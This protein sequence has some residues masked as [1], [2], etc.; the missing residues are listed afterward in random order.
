MTAG[1]CRLCGQHSELRLSHV[2]PAFVFRWLRET[3]GTGH[4][5]RS[6]EPNVRVQ[7]GLKRPWLCDACEGRL[8]RSETEFA[9]SLFYPYLANS[10]VRIRYSEW[11]MHFCTSLSW[12]VLKLYLEEQHLGD[13]EPHALDRAAEAEAAWRGVLL[14]QTPH[15]G[16]F[17]Q[18]ILPLDRIESATGK[19]ASNINRYLMRA[20]HIDI[21]S[22]TRSVFTYAK[23][24][25]FIV[26]GFV[27]EPKREQWRGTKVNA[28]HGWIEPKKYV[29][30]RAFGEYLNEKA[31]SMGER[32]AGMSLRQHAKVD[33]AFRKNVERYVESDAFQA[34]NAD[35]EMFGRDAFSKREEK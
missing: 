4:I 11:L 28:N 15:A 7:D 3:S 17:E 34:M 35:V 30:P 33:E 14:G 31:Q 12:R 27:H 18:H 2:L 1:A 32:L 10:G 5:R 8:N 16:A 6:D 22:G 25:R 26:L 19:L 13:W 24:G 23:L 21:L 29:L 20:I 9:N